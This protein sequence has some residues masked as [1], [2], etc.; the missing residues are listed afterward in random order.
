MGRLE[1]CN[2]PAWYSCR[3]T[4]P[5]NSPAFASLFAC[6]LITLGQLFLSIGMDE[7]DTEMV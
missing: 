7:L 6:E 4:N 2:A 1:Q 5:G 3:N